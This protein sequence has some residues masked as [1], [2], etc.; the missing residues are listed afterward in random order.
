MDTNNWVKE[1][2]GLGKC[3]GSLDDLFM[4]LAPILYVSNFLLAIPYGY[5]VNCMV[6]TFDLT[7]D[8]RLGFSTRSKFEIA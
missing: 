4:T 8:L 7:H 6:L 5:R 1:S 3:T 2:I